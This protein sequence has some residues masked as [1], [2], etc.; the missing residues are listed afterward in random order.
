MKK[1]KRLFVPFVA[2]F[3]CIVFI[4]RNAPIVA[5]EL[6]KQTIYLW[7]L[8][9]LHIQKKDAIP[10][11][12]LIDDDNG[13]GVFAVK[14]ICD[15][16]R[17]KV[18]FA[19]IPSQMSQTMIDSIHSWQKEGFGIALHG[20][21]HDDWRN[22]TYEQVV[23]DIEESEKWLKQNGFR[24]ESIKYIVS[25][26]GSNTK[27]VRKAIKD[28]GYQMVTGANIVNPDTEVFQLGRV[29]ITKDT[30]LEETRIWLNKARK[31]NLFVIL[32]THSSMPE[33]FSEEK[34]KAVLQMAIDMGF[35]YQ[36]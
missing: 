22:W 6:T 26:H 16:L 10:K 9:C 32:G 33:E 25:P 28:K 11:I 7:L 24:K 31:R 30:D 34:T 20:F 4:Y 8:N 29:M 15:A 18:T 23:E 17:I 36:H 12:I 2:A 5:G 21:S 3:V 19:I 35:E 13:D 14:K 1:R 27:A